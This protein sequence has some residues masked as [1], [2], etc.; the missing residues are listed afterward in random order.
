MDKL[1]LCHRDDTAENEI[2]ECIEL[3]EKIK[4]RH[5]I[6]YSVQNTSL[7]DE[8]DGKDLRDK[9]RGIAI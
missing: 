1:I 4:E 3:L 9:I 2:Y 8:Q 5:Q 6:D 7:L